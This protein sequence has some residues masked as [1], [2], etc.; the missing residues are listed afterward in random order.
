MFELSALAAT[1]GL[2]L[3]ITL[4]YFIQFIPNLPKQ[5]NNELDEKLVFACWLG[6]SLVSAWLLSRGQRT[7][8]EHFDNADDHD[9]D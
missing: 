6:V 4:G 8:R 1:W 7:R 2:T 3:V 9:D 5:S